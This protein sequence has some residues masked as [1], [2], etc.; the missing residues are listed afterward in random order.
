VNKNSEC[1][2]L[3]FGLGKQL[4][5]SWLGGTMYKEGRIAEAQEPVNNEQDTTDE[6]E[7]G[8]PVRSRVE[9]PAICDEREWRRF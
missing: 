6:K 2:R 3:I 1:V 8:L 9:E 7:V 5:E 4:N